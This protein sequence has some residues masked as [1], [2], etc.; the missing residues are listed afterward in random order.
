DAD[1]R[2]DAAI[3][4]ARY[5][6]YLRPERCA[7]LDCLV[8]SVRSRTRLLHPTPGQGRPG[9][10][11]PVFLINRLRGVAER[12]GHWLRPLDDWQP[13]GKNLRQEFRALA[14]HLFLLYPV[15]AFMDSVWDLPPG[16]EAFRQQ[17]WYIRLGRGASFR[18][19]N[20][21]LNLTRRM[22]NC[23]RQAPAH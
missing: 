2:I 3:K 22:E 17:S 16:P 10:V 5:Y 12:H 21:P 4:T 14:A 13:A 7:A 6:F 18:D 15:P 9:W 8:A 20:L 19:L 11:A 23:A 1:A